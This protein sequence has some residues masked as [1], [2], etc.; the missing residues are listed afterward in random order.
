MGR[1]ETL[2]YNSKVLTNCSIKK[3]ELNFGNKKISKKI[4]LI[5]IIL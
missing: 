1:A 2:T 5:E 3:Y 4:Q